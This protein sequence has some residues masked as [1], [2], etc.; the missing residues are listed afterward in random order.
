MLRDLELCI[1]T[2]RN[3]YPANPI[4]WFKDIASY[5]NGI[6]GQAEQTIALQPKFA[7]FPLSVLPKVRNV[8]NYKF[9]LINRIFLIIYFQDM[10]KTLNN[11]FSDCQAAVLQDAYAN[12]LANLGHEMSKSKLK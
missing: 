12:C 11:V 7:N 6:L 1:E 3:L 9:W 5:L 2:V 10:R 8:L 4:L